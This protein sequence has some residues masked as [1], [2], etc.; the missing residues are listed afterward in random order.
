M[1]NEELQAKMLEFI[2]MQDGDRFDEWYAS[3]RDFAATILSDFSEYLGLELVVP[4]HVPQLKRPEIDR[5]AILKE[6]MPEIEK[7]F[8]VAYKERN[9]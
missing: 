7:L 6:L 1:T 2:E 4:E 5:N 3:P 8:N 9:P